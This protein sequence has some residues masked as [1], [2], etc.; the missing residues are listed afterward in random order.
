MY[1]SV[2]LFPGSRGYIEE[3][4]NSLHSDS[5]EYLKNVR[6]HHCS[7]HKDIPSHDLPQDP[8]HLDHHGVHHVSGDSPAPDT[9]PGKVG[10]KITTTEFSETI[11]GRAN[12]DCS[13]SRPPR[14]PPP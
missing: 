3:E 2:F 11:P 8:P 7:S 1:V 4:K 13:T 9:G 6:L 5:A 14:P 12:Q 10:N